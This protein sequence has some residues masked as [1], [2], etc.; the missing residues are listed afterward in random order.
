MKNAT[1]LRSRPA[2]IPIG[3]T[4]IVEQGAVRF[5]LRD[6]YSLAVGLGWPSFLL[7]LLAVLIAVNAGFAVLYWAVPGSVAS[8]DRSLLDAFFFSVE[9][10]ATVGY[11]EM[12]PATRYGHFVSV[13]EIFSGMAFTAILTG[14]VFV[15][16]SRPRASFRYA[17]TVAIGLHQGRRT[18]MLRVANG[19]VRMLQDAAARVTLVLDTPRETGAVVRRIADLPLSRSSL[20]VFAMTWTLMHEIDDRSPL[21]GLGADAPAALGLRLFVSLEAYD[22]LANATVHDVRQYGAADVRFGVRFGDTVTR[23]PD[24]RIRVDLGRLGLLEPDSDAEH[25]MY[26]WAAERPG[27]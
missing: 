6:P 10:L 14:L 4:E 17:D 3:D 1:G 13:A 25:Q 5:D 11:G 19:R 21:H 22:P 15:R 7:L 23:Q 9:T 20:P 18:L 12:Y 26:E 27:T 8:S 24:G 16:F 2:V